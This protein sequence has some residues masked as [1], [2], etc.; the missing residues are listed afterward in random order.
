MT[1][2]PIIRLN[3]VSV[4]YGR[5]LALDGLDLEVRSGEMLALVGP[6]GAGK[7]TTLRVLVGQ[8]APS[9][10]RVTMVGRDLGRDWASLKGLFGYV[11]DRDNHFDE[12]SGRGN[13]RFFADLYRVP[14]QRVEECLQLLELT[15]VADGMVQAYS[16]GM[17]RK[18]LLARALLHRPRLLFLDEPTANLD[19]HAAG[20]VRG[21]LRDLADQGCTIVLATHDVPEAVE[22]CDRVAVLRQG[23]LAAIGAP[24]V[25]QWEASCVAT[26]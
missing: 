8:I 16:L 15:E 24:G 5:A 17:R 23:R 26:S 13:L 9:S 7:S 21:I 1:S 19:P 25:L 10:G 6:S 2:E 4:R 3:E 12:F 20:L 11:P 22:L 18:L 14:H